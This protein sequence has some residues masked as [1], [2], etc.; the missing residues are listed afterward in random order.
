MSIIKSAPP[1]GLGKN[2]NLA[3]RIVFNILQYLLNEI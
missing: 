2:N 1:T 3:L